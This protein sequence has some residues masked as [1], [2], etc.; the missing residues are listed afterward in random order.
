MMVGTALANRINSSNAIPEDVPSDVQLSRQFET[1][2]AAETDNV[3]F[4]RSYFSFLRALSTAAAK[5]RVPS[6]TP[7]TPSE[8]FKVQ[9]LKVQAGLHIRKG[10]RIYAV[11]PQA[12]FR[13]N[14]DLALGAIILYSVVIIPYRLGFGV[15]IKRPS[16]NFIVDSC[17]D[18]IFLSDMVLN[19]FTGYYDSNELFVTDLRLIRRHYLRTWFTVDLLSTVPVDLL[20]ELLVGG[21]GALRSL[22]L[23]RTLR[24]AK[25]ARLKKLSRV[26]AQLEDIGAN[27]AMMKLAK[28]LFNIVFAAHLLACM[29]GALATASTGDK[30]WAENYN[31]GD[32]GPG[33]QYVASLYWTVATM[34]GVGYGDIYAVNDGERIFSI[35]AQVIGAAVFG[36][37]IGHIS[38]LLEKLDVRAAALKNKMGVLREYM[39]ERRL[40]K[41]LQTRVR[42]LYEYQFQRG[43]VFDDN[44][45]LS[46]LSNNLRNK[47]VLGAHRDIV[48]NI[49][50]FTAMDASFISLVV[51]NLVP[52]YVVTGDMVAVAGEVGQ[53]MYFV[54][55]GTVELLI[56]IKGSMHLLGVLTDGAHMGEMSLLLQRPRA[57]HVRASSFCDM[58]FLRK[59]TL[60]KL[61]EQFPDAKEFLFD[62]AEK[63]NESLK[64]AIKQIMETGTSSELLHN[65]EL[66][67][68]REV[69][70]LVSTGRVNSGG[71]DRIVTRRNSM[72]EN[73]G[74]SITA[75][76]M[77]RR[78]SVM[79][80]SAQPSTS[81]SDEI[82]SPPSSPVRPS[83][84]PPL[85]KEALAENKEE[86]STPN[87]R[88]V[89]TNNVRESMILSP[90]TMARKM[91]L[92]QENKDT[93][94]AEETDADLWA[95]G[96]L[97][98]NG[99]FRTR[100]DILLMTMIMYSVVSI[101][102]RLGFQTEAS[103][104]WFVLDI[105]VDIFFFFDMCVNFRTGYMSDGILIT[106]PK[107]IATNYLKTWFALDL[108]STFP[109]DKVIGA[110]DSNSDSSVLRAFK[111]V[112][113]LRLARLF[114]LLK[115]S[116]FIAILENE[117][118]VNPALIHLTKLLLE[119][120]FIAHLLACGWYYVSSTSSGTACEYQYDC[121][122]IMYGGFDQDLIGSRYI[123]SIYWAFTTMT[124]VGYG[125]VSG[126]SNSERLFSVCCMLLG[127]TVFGYIVGSMAT[128]VAK[129]NHGE[130]RTKERLSEVKEWIKELS[131]DM[132]LRHR[133]I[134]YYEHYLTKQSVFD[135]TAI[136]SKLP[137]TLRHEVM[138]E[139]N[140]DMVKKVHFFQGQE[141][142]M[143]SFVMQLLVSQF[144]L[145]GD[146]VF[147]EGD[148]A[149]DM[150]F[151][152]RGRM[153]VLGREGLVYKVLEEGQHF[154]EVAL[155]TQRT[156]TASVR[157][158]VH[159]QVLALR[160]DAIESVQLRY[161]YLSQLLAGQLKKTGT[162]IQSQEFKMP[163]QAD[164]EMLQEQVVQATNEGSTSLAAPGVSPQR[165]SVVEP[166]VSG[167]AMR[168]EEEEEIMRELVTV[169]SPT[170]PS[171]QAK[172]PEPESPGV[173]DPESPTLGVPDPSLE[174]LAAE[175][176]K[177]PAELEKE[178]T[179]E[180]LAAELEAGA[181]D[182]E[183]GVVWPEPS[184]AQQDTLP[185]TAAVV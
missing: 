74:N 175:L 137:A 63:R 3:R 165:L 139:V 5:E 82:E 59:E 156:R 24:L 91:K 177:E 73:V 160:K 126:N 114:K 168:M 6:M 93:E 164:S 55:K 28:L 134:K 94:L 173:Q 108:V 158:V 107:R 42:K 167:V 110:L 45:I 85:S 128:V 81:I 68:A 143:V 141:D 35:I 127:V 44:A 1:K 41:D 60:E 184:D 117:L 58:F 31:I 21:G 129:I 38:T 19:F 47:V 79:Q 142:H 9:V 46:E 17:I 51:M 62:V 178:P 7:R 154:G 90:R 25:L 37:L 172:P 174:S 180:S 23:I 159:S 113:V 105:L 122:W 155:L 161:P 27:A 14:W 102:Y 152:V 22:K 43:S 48:T 138:M 67:D 52:F 147:R 50:M 163:T 121:N 57:S 76:E 171:P 4:E 26:V 182:V 123:T 119:V 34:T 106:I 149:N 130:Q 54:H 183:Q 144:Y 151:L 92:E 136:L 162:D 104:G 166:R 13:V 153:E 116:R 111:L 109:F 146:Y 78:V 39:N 80:R 97:N 103:G 71:A 185:G 112:R 61:M 36:F 69:E 18:V 133:V 89:H 157:A 170:V 118:L 64:E 72:P 75:M 100:W 49:A 98:P 115:L 83:V 16:A 145:P 88:A 181:N 120:T 29:W 10:A 70:R 125:D 11:D 135:E 30:N 20:V 148:S 12:S 53:E 32:E 77:Q 176:A 66:T 33:V 40:S 87:G 179:L 96:I 86:P 169:P 124:T 132:D 150:Y 131:L 2:G 84:V 15:E 56:T 95:R 8:R 140:K 65:D 99:S 101:P